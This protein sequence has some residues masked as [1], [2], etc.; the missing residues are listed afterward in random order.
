MNKKSIA[1]IGGGASALSF[2]SFIDTN[3]YDVT[4]YEKN[5]ALGRKF[6]VAGSGGF[7]LTHS[8]AIENFCLRYTPSEFISPFIQQF[9]NTDFRT[10]LQS[11]GIETYIG[12]SKR[13]FPKKGI[14][15]IQVLQAIETNLEK[16]NITIAYEHTWLGFENEGLRFAKKEGEVLVNADYRV[17]AL[18][19]SSWKVTGSEGEWPTY[20]KNKQIDTLP[21]QSSNGAFEVQWNNELLK[22]IEGTVIKNATFS[23]GNK[24]HKGEAVITT[25]GIEGS[26]VYSL[27]PIIRTQLTQ[28]GKAELIIDFKPDLTQQEIKYRLENNLQDSVKDILEKKINLNATHTLL[29]KELTTKEQYHSADYL[30]QLIKHYPVTITSLTPIDEAISTVGGISL[31]TVNKYLELKQL[32]QHYCLGEML[33]WDAPTGGYLLQACFSMGYAV[34]DRLNKL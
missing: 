2:A 4:I 17:F 21:F 22:Q 7:N 19:G 12:T 31:D 30:S 15:P 20:F 13:V 3:Q 1:I 14:K 18:G 32:P 23:C 26:G 9:T 16:K 33:N 27:S 5:T 25:F 29:L 6:L 8:E 24:Q 10:W 34:A 28:F 11:I